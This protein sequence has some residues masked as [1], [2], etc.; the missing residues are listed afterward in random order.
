[1]TLY[2][3]LI[4]STFEENLGKGVV[5]LDTEFQINLQKYRQCSEYSTKKL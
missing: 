3:Q 2:Y 1:M 5:K 4:C